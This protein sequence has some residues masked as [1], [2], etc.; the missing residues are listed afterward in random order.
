MPASDFDR[1]NSLIDRLRATVAEGELK[2]AARLPPDMELPWRL[3]R[4]TCA[5]GFSVSI[6]A[7]PCL[8]STPRGAGP[9]SAV[10]LGFPSLAESALVEYAEDPD[11]LTGTVYAFVPCEVLAEILDAHGWPEAKTVGNS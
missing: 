2:R 8:Y 10:E 4:V 6:Q 1:V 7:G 5:D 11:D 3:P 9:W